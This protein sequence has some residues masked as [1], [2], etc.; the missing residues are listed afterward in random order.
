VYLL[1][2]ACVNSSWEL[3]EEDWLL[4]LSAVHSSILSDVG[5]LW[6]IVS[7]L[8]S[9]R[10]SF[11]RS[12]LS[13]FFHVIQLALFRTCSDGVGPTIEVDVGISERF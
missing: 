3:I 8:S 1:G 13:L 6:K 10:Y 5:F 4:L 2:A 7:A 11:R 12:L 9:H